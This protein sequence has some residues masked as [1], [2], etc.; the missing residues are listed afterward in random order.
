MNEGVHASLELI[1]MSRCCLVIVFLTAW[2]HA[3]APA[4]GADV[5]VTCSTGQIIRGELLVA[6]DSAVIVRTESSLRNIWWQGDSAFAVFLPLSGVQTVVVEGHSNI[7][8]GTGI[9]LVLGAGLG[10]ASAQGGWAGAGAGAGGFI[11]GLLG[12]LVGVISSRSERVYDQNTRGGF[13]ALQ[14]H[15]LYGTTIPKILKHIK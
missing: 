1:Y 5:A 7:L 9:G 15:A 6:T 3:N 13:S 12:A 14:D 8:L 2:V 11:G 4:Q 10:A